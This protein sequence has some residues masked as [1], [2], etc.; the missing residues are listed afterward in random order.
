MAPIVAKS[1]KPTKPKKAPFPS[2]E[3]ILEFVLE[4]P[5][6]VGKREIARAF[7]LDS[8]QRVA[9]KQ[10]LRDLEDEGLIGRRRGRPLRSGAI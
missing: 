6:R 4:N 2:R 8:K 1:K 9:L 10:I 3:E 7:R 5:Q